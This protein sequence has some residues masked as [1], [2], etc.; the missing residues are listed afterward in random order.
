[1]KVHVSDC[2]NV[3]KYVHQDGSETAV[4]FNNNCDVSSQYSGP[5]NNVSIFISSDS[6]CRVGC[7]FCYL[8]QGKFPYK[9][10]LGAQVIDN[11]KEAISHQLS[12]DTPFKSKYVKFAFM[13]MGD[14]FSDITKT[15]DVIKELVDYT[16]GGELC[17]G[18]DGVD[19]GTV[20]PG[21]FSG[22]DEVLAE[23]CEYLSQWEINP[24]RKIRGPLR[25]FYSLHSTKN[26]NKLIP[27]S[28]RDYRSDLAYL[29]SVS[30]KYSIPL[31]F[32]QI[33]LNGVNDNTEDLDCVIDSANSCGAELR[34][35][36]YNR[37]VD[38][39]LEE[40]LLFD[41]LVSRVEAQANK[42][43]I[44]DSPGKDVCSACGQFLME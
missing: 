35:L 20:L 9:R 32:H 5:K 12:S 44:Q 18:L 21:D 37:H 43:K 38:S 25:L 8:S 15:L 41:N 4:K 24:V 17:R 10:L 29:G 23:M 34:V 26:R 3:Y 11:V 40:S 22:T 2:G 33:F 1:M 19:I 42:F 30:T 27:F 39:V 16:V 13:G 28:S 7:K 6:G 36:K 14:A 31:I